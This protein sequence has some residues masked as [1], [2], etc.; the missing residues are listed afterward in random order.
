MFSVDLGR[1]R[2]SF[3][4]KLCSKKPSAKSILFVVLGIFL[5]A[6]WG[7]DLWG[8]SIAVDEEEQ[9][10][11]KWQRAVREIKFAQ[12]HPTES[13]SRIVVTEENP[14]FVRTA[15]VQ[16]LYDHLRASS[17]RT[18]AAEHAASPDFH[19]VECVTTFSGLTTDRLPQY[20]EAVRE[21]VMNRQRPT[22]YR[23]DTISSFATKVRVNASIQKGLPE[24]AGQHGV[25]AVRDIAENICIGQY[26][27]DEYL[28]EEFKA[29]FPWKELKGK[30]GHPFK[31]KHVYEMTQNYN[32][33]D[34]ELALPPN[35][36][37]A[38]DGFHDYDPSRFPNGRHSEQL[39]LEQ[40]QKKITLE[41]LINDPR[42]NLSKPTMT[43]EDLLR[44]NTEFVYCTV[45]GVLLS[46]VVTH[47]EIKAGEQLFIS[48]GPNYIN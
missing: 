35:T 3:L 29:L 42:A 26:Y 30:K 14:L 21:F 5:G 39:S 23:Q 22:M 1:C 37:V 28:R 45:D 31:R 17:A 47:K 25:V 6:I 43:A 11:Q 34:L 46:F 33:L 24:W 36:K 4:K 12:N 38:I 32:F 20:T 15:A 2:R 13:L 18:H 16:S 9:F 44:F 7:D 48:Y 10:V 40:S 8:N 27:G 19:H 41:G